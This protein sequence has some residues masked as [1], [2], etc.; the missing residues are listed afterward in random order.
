MRVSCTPTNQNTHNDGMPRRAR[1]RRGSTY[2]FSKKLQQKN[3]YTTTSCTTKIC[4]A[5]VPTP[6]GRTLTAYSQGSKNQYIES[7]STTTSPHR[8]THHLTC[9]PH[10]SHPPHPRTALLVQRILLRPPPHTPAPAAPWLHRAH[11]TNGGPLWWEAAMPPL[12]GG[13]TVL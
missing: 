2:L 7:Y 11:R 12:S 4:T 8:A 5:S 13:L 9:S 3:S 10:A 1:C 6:V